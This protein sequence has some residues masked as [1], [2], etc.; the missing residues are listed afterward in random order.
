MVK[1]SELLKKIEEGNWTAEVE[2]DEDCY[3]QLRDAEL[4]HDEDGHLSLT[5]SYYY[6]EDSAKYG[7]SLGEIVI[8]IDGVIFSCQR[9]D[10]S[11][12][13]LWELD[14][15]EIEYDDEDLSEEDLTGALE[16]KSLP[17]Y[18][19]DD[20]ELDES[21]VTAEELKNACDDYPE[22][23]VET[24]DGEMLGFDDEEDIPKGAKPIELLTVIERLMA[25]DEVEFDV[26]Y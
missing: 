22:F 26:Q 21:A 15:E 10:D 3:P 8:K 14:G 5:A 18:N 24:E 16:E 19:P 11:E 9:I 12:N 20:Y 4:S 2:N 25:A 17:Y 6:R 7:I 13:D 1:A 23:L